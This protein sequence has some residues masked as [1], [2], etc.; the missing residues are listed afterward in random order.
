MAFPVNHQAASIQLGSHVAIACSGETGQV[1]GRA[2]YTTC[3]TSYLVRYAAG[4]G[5]AVE[6]WWQQSA[7]V[8]AN[9][10]AAPQ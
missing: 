3:E 4:D 1:V 7:L 8:V 6:Q 10:T 5:R 9:P 2:E